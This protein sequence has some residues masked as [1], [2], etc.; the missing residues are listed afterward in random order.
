MEWRVKVKQKCYYKQVGVGWGRTKD[1]CQ[2][3]FEFYLRLVKDI[4][5][6]FEKRVT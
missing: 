3:T 5:E 2:S 4:L 6:D 1:I